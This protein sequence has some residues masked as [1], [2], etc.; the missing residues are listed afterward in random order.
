MTV[1]AE[2]LT[3][4]P[5]EK[6]K[7]ARHGDDPHLGYFT[8][9]LLGCAALWLLE[10]P[11]GL[12]TKAWHLFIIFLATIVSVILKVMPMAALSLCAIGAATLTHTLT[13]EESLSSFS[14]PITWLIVFA[15]LIARGFILTGLGSRIAYFFI[16]LLGKST[17][18][19]A[20]GFALTEAL[21]ALF[22]PSSVA[23]GGGIVFPII[24]ALNMEYQ[25]TPEL[26]TER[27][28]GAYLMKVCFQANTI[29]STLFL[30]AIVSNPLIVSFATQ[31][32]VSLTWGQWALMSLVPGVCCLLLMPLALYIL[33]PPKIKETPQAPA[34]ARDKLA[35]MG[36]L[37]FKEGVMLFT[38]VL[39]LGLWMGSK[40]LGIDPTVTALVG[41]LILVF[42]GVLT[43]TDILSEKGAWDTMIW[44]AILLSLAGFLGK[45][46]MM[47]W[48]A[49]HIETF[50]SDWPWEP[51]L[52]VLVLVFFYSHYFFASV[53]AHVAS[54]FGV[55]FAV[56]VATG[57]PPG[58]ALALLGGASA[59]F[60]CLTHYGTGAAPVYFGAGYISL[61]DWWVLGAIL[62]VMY[63]SI[64]GV[65][66]TAWWKVLGIW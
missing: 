37:K 30:T 35:H 55:F 8:L 15:F 3:G 65:V 16:S 36:P 12:E 48:A 32:G 59:M 44:F 57:A 19:L 9:V 17:L 27:N 18:G 31:E 10:T 61:R 66:G 7:R 2:T 21:L 4:L 56:A 50:V 24:Q 33:Y 53:T 46:G 5:P 63:L 43:W 25:S 39:L 14:S 6:K 34:I 41:V 42:S 26:G 58:L 60:G 40:T 20:Y 64:W 49:G 51:S 54:L 22:I 28:M 62:S 1:P 47:S 52:L 23:R 38:F 11:A 13:L 29:S 45:F